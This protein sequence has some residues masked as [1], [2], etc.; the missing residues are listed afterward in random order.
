MISIPVFAAGDIV[1]VN[2]GDSGGGIQAIKLPISSPT[3]EAA[4]TSG[5]G[6]FTKQLKM[7]LRALRTGKWSNGTPASRKRILDRAHAAKDNYTGPW[8]TELTYLWRRLEAARPNWPMTD[9]V[10]V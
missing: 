2:F 10:G 6:R 1:L 8:T 3:H 9:I 4:D 7:Y 5:V